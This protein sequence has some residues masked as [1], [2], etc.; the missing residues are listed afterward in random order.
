M[1]R[2]AV[3][4]E[5]TN[6]WAWP[7]IFSAELLPQR[8]VYHSAATPSG[9]QIPDSDSMIAV[10]CTSPLMVTIQ[11][12]VRHM[13]RGSRSLTSPSVNQKM[14]NPIWISELQASVFST[15]H[16]EP[17]FELVIKGR[18]GVRHPTGGS[19]DPT[20]CEAPPRLQPLH[21]GVVMTPDVGVAVGAS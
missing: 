4:I 14:S 5:R 8:C 16:G 18:A 19:R 10:T 1:R 3:K 11:S 17:A 6:Q 15:K 9:N 20:S 21:G 12:Q 7:M 13:S 2:V